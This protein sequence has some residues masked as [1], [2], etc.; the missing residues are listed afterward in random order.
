MGRP[1]KKIPLY[2]RIKQ[3]RIERNLWLDEIS[4]KANVSYVTYGK[5]ESGY[6]DNPTIKN[7]ARICRVLEISIDDVVQDMDWESEQKKL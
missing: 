5:I 1:R 6:T 3:A 2:E 7:L 4:K